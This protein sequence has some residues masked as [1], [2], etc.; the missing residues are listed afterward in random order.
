M[1]PQGASPR[2]A[3]GAKST[4]PKDI[5]RFVAMFVVVLIVGVGLTLLLG[6]TGTPE[7]EPEPTTGYA[8][9][10]AWVDLGL[11]VKWATCNVGASSPSEYGNYYAWGETSP[12]SEYFESNSSTYGQRVG[13]IG[14]TNRDAARVNW[15]GNW[16]LPTEE[17]CKELVNNC[18][19]TWTN[20]GYRV[21]G[22]NGNSI[23]LPAS[24]YRQGR[25]TAY[26][27]ETGSY[28][29]S[30]P[31]YPA[32]WAEGLHFYRNYIGSTAMFCYRG[33]S[34]RPVLA[35]NDVEQVSEATT[36]PEPTPTPAPT[37]AP[38]PEPQPQPTPQPPTPQPEPTP[39]PTPDPTP[40]P[41]SAP[42]PEPVPQQ[43]IT[44]GYI[45]GH[46]YV[47][48]GLSVKWATCNVGASNPSDYGNYYAW[49][50]TSPKS[51]YTTSNS[52]TYGYDINGDIGGTSRDAA[53]VNWGGTWRLP[54][55]AECEELKNRC[56]WT[57]TNQ[58]GHNGYQV[59]GPNGN[60]IFLPAG[61]YRFDNLSYK[62]GVDGQYWSSISG[63]Y[64]ETGSAWRLLI[65]PSGREVSW[66]GRFGGRSVRPVSK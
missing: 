36:V 35:A 59:T 57:R 45:N 7:P 53:R 39:E 41:V 27:G 12:K 51:E 9:G 14:G 26:V 52:S 21:T 43:D 37:P 46:E 66:S 22:P 11:S 19:W 62:V 50:E 31:H 33:H 42:E 20:S 6:R 1:L 3:A 15:G 56:T 47:D 32:D 4:K 60:S 65:H 48:L 23:F 13:D 38:E 55:Q 8:N 29:S 61:G 5:K 64:T 30:T 24:G 44:T 18:T 17:E 28:L 25:G 40:E 34:V 16:R 49:G 10:H 2:R 58:N 63:N 54:T